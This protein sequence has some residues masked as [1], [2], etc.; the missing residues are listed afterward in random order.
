MNRLNRSAFNRE[1][2]SLAVMLA[3]SFL[4]PLT[5]LLSPETPLWGHLLTIG[6]MV[7][8]LLIA[9]WALRRERVRAADI[10]LSRDD[11]LRGVGL[12][13]IWWL[14]VGA[15]EWGGAAIAGMLGAEVQPPVAYEWDLTRVLD[16]GRAWVAVGFVEELA[17]R[18]YLHNKLIAMTGKRWLGIALAAL[19]FGVWHMPHALLLGAPLVSVLL[20]ALVLS[21]F[22]AVCLNLTYELTG[23]LPFVVLFHGWNDFAL[24]PNLKRPS[25]IGQIGGLVLIVLVAAAQWVVAHKRERRQLVEAEEE[26]SDMVA[27]D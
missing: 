11:W 9:G 14:L 22:S 7:I 21:A 13:A 26:E 5:T 3:L 15:I 16:F 23:L 2:I 17:F 20:R 19:V 27:D 4:V 24:L 1:P 12:F 6:N 18:G 8:L 25:N 10:G